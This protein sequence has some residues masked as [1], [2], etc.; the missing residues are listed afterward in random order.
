MPRCVLLIGSVVDANT[1]LLPSS[2]VVKG[3]CV[4]PSTV[5]AGSPIRRIVPRPTWVPVI[6]EEEAAAAARKAE[7]ADDSAGAGYGRRAS[8]PAVGKEEM[9]EEDEEDGFHEPTEEE[10]IMLRRRSTWKGVRRSTFRRS[11]KESKKSSL[12]ARGRVDALVQ[13]VMDTEFEVSSL[14]AERCKAMAFKRF[15][16]EL[17][18]AQQLEPGLDREIMDSLRDFVKSNFHGVS[19]CTTKVAMLSAV[20]EEVT[21]CCEKLAAALEGL[22]SSLGPEAWA[23]ADAVLLLLRTNACFFPAD[24][25]AALLRDQNHDGN[26]STAL[27]TLRQVPPPF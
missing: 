5:C 13:L 24:E 26:S 17:E 18:E 9:E 21:F 4:P 11:R 27:E 1:T 22:R 6:E 15:A 20:K 8:A 7:D 19:H 3:E 12:G 10:S 2:L 16:A 25:A 14:D 23:A